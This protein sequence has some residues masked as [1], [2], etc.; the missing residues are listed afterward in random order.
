MITVK[1]RSTSGP[2]DPFKPTTVD[3]RDP[4]P[5]DVLIDI[6]YCGVCHTDVTHSRRL[7]SST[8]RYPLVPGHEITGVVSAVG[9]E[10]TAFAVG[11]RVGVGCMVDS[12]REC[13]DCRAGLEQYC[14]VRHVKTYNDLGWD[15][16][17]TI[18]GY[19]EKVVVDQAYVVRI[20]ETL[21]MQNAAS[22]LCAGITMY[23]PLRHWKA[24]AGKRVAI[25]GYGG[26]GHLGVAF[27]VALGAH[28]TVLEVT[29]DKKDDALGA[30]ADGYRLT[31]DPETFTDLAGFFDLI[32]S[33]VPADLDYD[34][35]LKLLARDGTFVNLGVPKGPIKVEA[36]SLLAGRRSLAG[37]LIGGIEETQEMLEFCA[38]HDVQSQIEMIDA[39]RIDE[40]FDRVSAGDVRYRFV[41]DI[42]TLAD[43]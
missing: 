9:S 43:V 11:D 23:S 19:C 35:F 2:T 32:I 3:L 7:R 42:S 24:S 28:T 13:E 36:F 29:E 16:Q 33:S 27:S 10:V 18:G 22:L 5:A 12:C 17:P 30:G 25:V 8:T 26:L 21:P 15:G 39:D 31:T 14:R 38:E 34:A 37:S 40:A 20:P 6:A 4:R 41:I 1:A